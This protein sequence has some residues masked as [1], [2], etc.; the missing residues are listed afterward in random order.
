MNYKTQHVAYNLAET[1]KAVGFV[2]PVYVQD[3]NGEA[4]VQ[5]DAGVNLAVTS[6]GS[7]AGSIRILDQ[8]GGTTGGWLDI[9]NQNQRVFT[10]GVV[11]LLVEG[12]GGLEAFVSRTTAANTVTTV[13]AAKTIAATGAA[14]TQAD[15]GKVITIS[16]A[17]ADN[18]S[19]RIVG[20]TNTTTVVV[21]N[22]DGSAV[23]FSA[24]AGS[25]SATITASSFVGFAEGYATCATVANGNTL[26]ISVGGSGSVTLTAAAAPANEGE[27]KTE[28]DNTTQAATIAAAINAHSVLKRY[29]YATSA[30]AVVTVRSVV[31]GVIGNGIL[32]TGTAVTLLTTSPVQLTGVST[33]MNLAGGSGVP[34][35]TTMK[36]DPFNR[37]VGMALRS[38]MKFELWTVPAGTAPTMANFSVATKVD[39]LWPND[40]WTISAL[41]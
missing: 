24:V 13:N 31:P 41:V 37:I 9:A 4:G 20:I 2:N 29:V 7:G 22:L 21:R 36:D 25:G 11:Q 6:P 26:V 40:Y 28:A 8:R 27:F 3:S 12:S 23:T 5:F 14:F 15:L 10:T 33:A 39:E 34:S 1:L 17:T 30:L 19:Y 32:M 16:G 35:V 18:G 38:G